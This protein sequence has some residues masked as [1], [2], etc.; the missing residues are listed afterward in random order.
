MQPEGDDDDPGDDRQ[1]P[2]VHLHPLAEHGR[3]GSQGDEHGGEAQY[4]AERGQHDAPPQ[5]SRDP[6]LVG[7]LLDGGA[8]DVARYGGTSGSTHGD[9]KLTRPAS[10]TPRWM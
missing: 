10:A 5:W 2:L 1:L 6:G 3:A 4:E 8:A 7:H 9:R